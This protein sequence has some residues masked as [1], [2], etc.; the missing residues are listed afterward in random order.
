[1]VFNTRN[2]KMSINSESMELFDYCFYMSVMMILSLGM[3]TELNAFLRS[4]R[5]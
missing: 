1:M 2:K 3:T 4:M 5:K